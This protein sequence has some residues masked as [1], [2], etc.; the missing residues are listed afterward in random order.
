MFNWHKEAEMKWDEKA[1]FWN[2][3]SREMWD[4]GSR[5][6]IIPFFEQYI[7]PPSTVLDAGCGDGYGSF[8]LSK[9]GYDVTGIDISHQMINNASKH[10]GGESLKFVQGDLA[11]LPFQDNEFNALIAVNS[12]EWTQDPLVVLH[13]MKRVIKQKGHLCVAIL[14]PTAKP[15][16]N[17]Y[18]RL[19]GDFV[20]CNTMMPWEFKRLALENGFDLVDGQGIYKRGVTESLVSKFPEEL[21]Q[22]LTFMWVF[23]FQKQ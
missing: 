10:I 1:T 7:A 11:R 14:G 12:I 4:E 9:Q 16:E 2:N 23:M 21:K 13:E 5:S 18:R 8:K 6:T 3:N 15:R 17:S 20:I 22:S 19:Y